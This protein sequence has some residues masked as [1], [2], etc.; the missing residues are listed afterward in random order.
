MRPCLRARVGAESPRRVENTCVT[1][2]EHLKAVKAYKDGKDK[3][4]SSG[5]TPSLPL[6]ATDLLQQPA[7]GACEGT[8]CGMRLFSP[9]SG[10]SYRSQLKRLTDDAAD[11][12]RWALQNCALLP[13]VRAGSATYVLADLLTYFVMAPSSAP[14]GIVT[15]PL[16]TD[17]P[18][19]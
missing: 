8:F 5:P 12:L 16:I 4:A 11:R 7:V 9:L 6:R 1:V 17:I 13:G 3:E 19:H 2:R 15:M 18:S 14:V 10:A